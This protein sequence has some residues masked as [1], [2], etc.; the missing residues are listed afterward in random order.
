M[1]VANQHCLVCG[2]VAS[3]L[4]VLPIGFIGP[5]EC[6]TVHALPSCVAPCRCETCQRCLSNFSTF[7]SGQVS[8]TATAEQLAAAFRAQCVASTRPS[9]DCDRVEKAIA[10]SFK[11][12]LARRVGAICRVL[13]ECDA[14]LAS[15]ASCVLSV[16]SKSGSLSEC[17]VDGVSS[18]EDVVGIWSG[19]G[20]HEGWKAPQRVSVKDHTADQRLLVPF[21][22]ALQQ[23]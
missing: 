3:E 14:G 5:G 6:F 19:A 20:E 13:G 17:R 9:A 8:S 1:Y 21:W 16:G 18:G 2:F 23:Q 10:G 22:S 7:V 11:G 4:V 15:N 12:N